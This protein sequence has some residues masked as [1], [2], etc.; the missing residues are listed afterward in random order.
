[1]FT[2]VLTRFIS[3]YNRNFIKTKIGN[4]YSDT[5]IWEPV[6]TTFNGDEFDKE[7]SND[8]RDVTLIDTTGHVRK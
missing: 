3:G 8:V 2:H 7:E 1:M 4:G 6:I 5:N